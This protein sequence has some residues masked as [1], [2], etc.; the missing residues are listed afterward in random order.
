MKQTIR[1]VL[2]GLM[3]IPMVAWSETDSE[4]AIGTTMDDVLATLGQPEGLMRMGDRAWLTFARGTI[5]LENDRVIEAQLISNEAAVKKRQMEKI[6]RQRHQQAMAEQR[7]RHLEQGWALKMARESNPEFQAAPASYQVSFWKEFQT[8]YPEIPVHDQYEFALARYQQEQEQWL[9]K[10]DQV[11]RIRELEIR[12][13]QAER[14]QQ[15]FTR[16]RYVQ[17]PVLFIPCTRQPALVPTK[18]VNCTPVAFSS[19]GTR[20]WTS[21]HFSNRN[22]P[23]GMSMAAQSGYY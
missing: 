10:Q 7:Q 13:Q 20:S 9:L 4:I 18:T 22:R 5:K 11:N 16:V 3:I 19:G 6:E 21:P 1:K 15:R 2:T 17:T 8:R 23:V 14:Q 12:V